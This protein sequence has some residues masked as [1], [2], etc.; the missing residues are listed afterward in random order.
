MDGGVGI[1]D[2]G[3][4]QLGGLGEYIVHSFVNK[5]VVGKGPW[6]GV[7]QPDVYIG[8]ECV[9]ARPFFRVEAVGRFNDYFMERYG[10]HGL[11]YVPSEKTTLCKLVRADA[12]TQSL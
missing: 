10:K 1:V 7:G 11:F 2:Q 12:A 4:Q 8:L 5:G 6:L 3:F 9:I